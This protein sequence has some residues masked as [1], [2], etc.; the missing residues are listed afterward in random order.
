MSEGLVLVLALT[1][2]LA[3]SEAGPLWS[4][5]GVTP[6]LCPLPGCRGDMRD[7]RAGLC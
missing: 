3:L 5:N 1:K 7:V 2:S 4:L 6:E